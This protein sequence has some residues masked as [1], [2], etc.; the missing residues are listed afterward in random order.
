MTAAPAN[1]GALP[2]PV[3]VSGRCLD[4]AGA[5]QTNGTQAQIWDCDGGVDQRWTRT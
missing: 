1:A 4:V 2:D 5:S 3:V